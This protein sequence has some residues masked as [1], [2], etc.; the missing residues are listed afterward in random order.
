M[1][2]FLFSI[3]FLA[4]ISSLSVSAPAQARRVNPNNINQTDE[5][6]ELAAKDL[7][8]EANSYT[9]KKFAEFES[10]K[11]PYSD[12]LFRQTVQEHK[13]LAAKNAA[14]LIRRENLADEDLYYLGMLNWMAENADNAAEN[15][16]KFL[17]SENTASEKLQT[18]RSV[19]IVL[20]ARR[21][22][23]DTAEKFLVEYLNTDPV[24]LSELARM[25]SEFAAA[26]RD[27]KN[28][29]KAAAHAEQ[30]YRATK[31]VFK[32]SRSRARGL[33][34]IFDTGMTAFEIY[35]AAKKQKEADTTLEDLRKTGAF[36]ES[37]NLYFR[38][39][40]EKIKYLID[41][42]RKPEALV[43]YQTAL[44]QSAKDF[45]AKPLRDDVARRMKRRESQ[46]RMLG[47]KAPELTDVDRWLDGT[48]HSLE[49]LRGKVVLLDFWATWCGP[50]IE[51]F[52]ELI[53]WHQ[54][55]KSEGLEILG[56]TRYY[57]EAG[58]AKVDKTTEIEFLRRFKKTHRLPYSFVISKD[59][60]NQIVYGA[61]SIPTMVLID[62]QGVVRYLQTGAGRADEIREKIEELLAEK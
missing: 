49:N 42:K 37:S 11:L 54:N 6:S 32:D 21:K 55:Y 25:E 2:Y 34:D 53:E 59:T 18:A 16:Q 9:K 35:K 36:V 58:G 3:L 56:V 26:Y 17:A 50:C 44:A 48:P 13:Q 57:G 45:T 52:P 12:T 22:N 14:V 61:S 15:L 24:K 30:A 7:Y 19:V 5:L 41:T 20:S 51:S 31:A 23:F 8:E 33:D 40:D 29:E 4:L 39:I 28:F 62:R 46:Y 27:E 60:T 10:K 1:R 38:A 43:Y 47:E